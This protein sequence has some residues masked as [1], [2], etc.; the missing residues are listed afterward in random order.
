MALT[1]V[2][3]LTLTL[4]PLTSS[5]CRVRRK[6]LAAS[7]PVPRSL[8]SSVTSPPPAS[9]EEEAEPPLGFGPGLPLTPGSCRE[10]G[11]EDRGQV[12]AWEDGQ[13]VSGAV[14][15]SE[16][17]WDDKA[18]RHWVRVGAVYLPSSLLHCTPLAL[19]ALDA[20]AESLRLCLAALHAR[21][22]PVKGEVDVAHQP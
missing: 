10:G 7:G 6:R 15:Q 22:F 2:R 1:R 18:S 4:T 3:T 19:R 13:V 9:D 16:V 14:V 12:V 17:P 11:G 20:D 5:D 21:P 8:D